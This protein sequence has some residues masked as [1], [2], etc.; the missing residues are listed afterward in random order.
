MAQIRVTQTYRHT[1]LGAYESHRTAGA[2]LNDIAVLDATKAREIRYLEDLC[3]G[4]ADVD[5]P[6]IAAVNGPAVSA[7][8]PGESTPPAPNTT[9]QQKIMKI[10]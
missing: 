1:V 9:R 3:R 7:T 10:E 5:K 4:M 8:C 6:V 2:D